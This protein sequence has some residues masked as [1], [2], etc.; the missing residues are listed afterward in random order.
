VEE[1]AAGHQAKL[2]QGFYLP[3]GEGASRRVIYRHFAAFQPRLG[4]DLFGNRGSRRREKFRL[5]HFLV[6]GGP[7]GTDH[8][9]PSTLADLPFTAPLRQQW[10]RR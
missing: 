1:P 2:N 6:T 5:I 3:P 8:V 10:A 4:S 7:V 9:G